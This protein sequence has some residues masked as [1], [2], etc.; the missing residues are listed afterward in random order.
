[1]TKYNH[2]C[3]VYLVYNLSFDLQ[4][5]RK[6]R[7]MTIF[8]TKKP[9]IPTPNISPGPS[10]PRR[11]RPARICPARANV[12]PT[13]R[14]QAPSRSYP[15]HWTQQLR[16]T[17][18]NI[19]NSPSNFPNLHS[20]ILIRCPSSRPNLI[21]GELPRGVRRWQNTRCSNNRTKRARSRPLGF[22][23]RSRPFPWRAKSPRR[24]RERGTR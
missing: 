20:N 15:N 1:M 2:G 11:Q 14:S 8:R 16:Q 19:T 21:P 13:D 12:L 17:P 9:A 4:K 7:P 18:T 22:P 23:S 10:I 5:C 3:P 6:S 24:T